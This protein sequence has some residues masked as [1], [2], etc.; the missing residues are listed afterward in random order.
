M[1][2]WFLLIRFARAVIRAVIR[3]RRTLGD[4]WYIV[5]TGP[6]KVTVEAD[7]YDAFETLYRKVNKELNRY[8]LKRDI[9]KRMLGPFPF[10]E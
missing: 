9:W 10:L 1:I 5:C 3:C 2:K 8:R 4:R 7:V 6:G